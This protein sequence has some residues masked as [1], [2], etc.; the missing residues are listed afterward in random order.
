M[1]KLEIVMTAIPSAVIGAGVPIAALYYMSRGLSPVVG[2]ITIFFSL[3]V[4]LVLGVVGMGIG[5]GEKS[6]VADLE[7]IRML[8]AGLRSVAED[9]DSSVELLKEIRDLLSVGEQNERGS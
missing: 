2:F 1:S 6:D 4:A 7:R 8:R 5:Y 3:G 9:L